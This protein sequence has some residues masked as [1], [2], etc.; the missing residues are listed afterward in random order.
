VNGEHWVEDRRRKVLDCWRQEQ[1][2]PGRGNAPVGV[3]LAFDEWVPAP[4]SEYGTGDAGMGGATGRSFLRS[5][6]GLTGLLCLA[7]SIDP[8]WRGRDLSAL[9]KYRG[10]DGWGP[11]PPKHKPGDKYIAIGSALGIV[12]GAV[13]G[14]MNNFFLGV[15]GIIAGGVVGALLG[16]LHARSRRNTN[17]NRTGGQGE[18]GLSN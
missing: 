13:L 16:S 5:Q 6:A 14:F 18:G 7:D 1:V 11:V 4:V 12:A 17:T 3:S 8:G 2:H 15:L 10:T 9:L